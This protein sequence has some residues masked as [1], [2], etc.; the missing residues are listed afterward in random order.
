LNYL[1]VH[2]AVYRTK[3]VTGGTRLTDYAVT[4]KTLLFFVALYTKYVSYLLPRI[5]RCK[6]VVS[7]VP[8]FL[9]E[10]AIL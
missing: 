4:Q 8:P 6:A 2:N 10:E 3:G 5:C 7:R 1:N 9:R